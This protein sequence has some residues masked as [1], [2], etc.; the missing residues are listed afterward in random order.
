MGLDA[1]ARFESLSSG[2]KR[3]VLL[4]RAL[5]ADPD[6]LLLDEP[7]NHLD[8]EAIRWLEDFLIRYGGT[9]VFVTHDR[10]F[11][12]RL[13]TRIAELDRG[14]LDDWA[15][16]Y[17]TFLERKEQLLA[18]EERQAALFDKKLAQEEVWIRK[19]IEARRTR[20]EGRVRALKAMR[21]ARLRRRERQGTA[22]MQ[23]QEAERSGSLVIEAKGV[24]F[25]YGEGEG[26]GEASPAGHPRPDRDDHAGRQGG[27][28]RPERLGQDDPAAPPARR[29]GAPARGR[30][31]TG[32]T[33]RSP[34]STS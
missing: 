26:D 6:I 16:D 20:N 19:G 4:A 27:D 9:L 8:I 34:T 5:V 13:A 25:G 23:V 1:D 12:G 3:R 28:H 15:C 10:A 29:P 31:A 17:A 33:S 11:L 14:R 30:S 2:M 24:G 7:T 21:E 32:R 18:A 22:R